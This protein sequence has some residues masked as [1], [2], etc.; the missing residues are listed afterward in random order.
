M[1]EDMYK[2]N[3]GNQEFSALANGIYFIV[4]FKKN[5][6]RNVNSPIT[7]LI[8]KM[9][10]PKGRIQNPCQDYSLFFWIFPFGPP[11]ETMKIKVV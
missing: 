9:G 2:P 6:L 1:P 3:Y 7:Y 5:Q 8:T 4:I 10:G 11:Y